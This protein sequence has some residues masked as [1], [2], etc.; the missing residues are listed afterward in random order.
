MAEQLK[1][2]NPLVTT[3][4]FVSTP[5]TLKDLGK[6]GER[7]FFVKIEF[8]SLEDAVKAGNR[9]VVWEMQRQ[10]RKG[11]IE[12]NNALTAYHVD[13]E[14]RKFVSTQEVLDSLTEE[15][16]EA[17]LERA[18]ARKKALMEAKAK[19]EMANFQEPVSS[20]EFTADELAN[21]NAA[22]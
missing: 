14:G 8:R 11:L 9:F 7:A 5:D 17:Q 10:A 2:S 19:E 1:S 16:L 6:K 18:R 20:D 4:K 13:S 21:D 3:C 12:P 15:Q 22:E